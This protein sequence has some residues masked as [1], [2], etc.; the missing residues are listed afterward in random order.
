VTAREEKGGK[1]KGERTRK[2]SLR[3]LQRLNPDLI[4]QPANAA[5][6]KKK[7]KRKKGESL[8]GFKPW[9]CFA[10]LKPG[11]GKERKRRKK[12]FW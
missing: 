2:T 4:A 11:G 7:K 12:G 8:S 10:L 6:G 5:R 1:K 9:L 3:G